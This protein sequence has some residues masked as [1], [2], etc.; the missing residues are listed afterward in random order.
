MVGLTTECSNGTRKAPGDAGAHLQAGCFQDFQDLVALK[1]V[2]RMICHNFYLLT[3]L[4]RNLAFLTL[5]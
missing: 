5:L 4:A 3:W 1:A 2:R